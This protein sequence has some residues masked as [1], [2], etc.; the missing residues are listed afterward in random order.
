MILYRG[1]TLTTFLEKTC[2]VSPLHQEGSA[3]ETETL[4][5]KLYIAEDESKHIRAG[6]IMVG[7]HA[8]QTA[9]KMI[10]PLKI[11]RVCKTI[12]PKHRPGSCTK[13]RCGTCAGNHALNDHPVEDETVKCPICGKG[14]PTIDHIPWTHWKQAFQQNSRGSGGSQLQGTHA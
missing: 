2:I 13:I 10:V 7:N 9:P 1:L 8:F 14:T 3:E 5:L 11:C 12:D 6:R 4:E